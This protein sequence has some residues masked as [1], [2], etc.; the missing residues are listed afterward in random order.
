MTNLD[1]YEFR[2]KLESEALLSDQLSNNSALLKGYTIVVLDLKQDSKMIDM[3]D[4]IFHAFG[5][6]GIKVV[7]NP[8]AVELQLRRNDASKCLVY[9]NSKNEFMDYR[10][11]MSSA[12]SQTKRKYGV[13]D[14]EWVVQCVISKYIWDPVEFVEV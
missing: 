13:V 8:R 5:A 1:V 2:A 9:D 7:K 6:S 11:S 14:W 10:M 4:F 3:C 12:L